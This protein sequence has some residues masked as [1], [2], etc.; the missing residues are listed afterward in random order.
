MERLE[1][2]IMRILLDTDLGD[3]IDDAYALVFA[4]LHPNIELV[5]VTTVWGDTGARAR[6]ARHLLDLWGYG[7]VPVYAGVGK[8]ILGSAQVDVSQAQ[9]AMTPPNVAAASTVH[10]VDAIRNTYAQAGSD[11]ALVTIGPLMNL[12]LALA[13]DPSLAERIPHVYVMGGNVAEAEPEWNIRCDPIASAVVL[14]SGVPLTLV[15]FNVTQQTWLDADHIAALEAVPSE[16]MRWLMQLTQAWHA[17]KTYWPVLHDPLT[18]AIAADNAL[19][20]TERVA[21][22]VIDPGTTVVVPDRE[23]T[24]TVA[25]EV[26]GRGFARLF[27]HMLVETQPPPPA[28]AGLF[29]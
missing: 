2:T 10:A 11:I 13:V 25:T 24:V 19:V 7:Y 9:L 16:P 1:R 15:P 6:M 28:D 4:L 17:D 12:G 23:P 29:G 5:G 14:R 27:A 21:L 22:D 20:R 26:D 8:P 3:D 18:V